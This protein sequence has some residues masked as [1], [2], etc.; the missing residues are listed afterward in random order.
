MAWLLSK[1]RDVLTGTPRMVPH[2]L[3]SRAALRQVLLGH[4]LGPGDRV[5]DATANGEFTPILEF[6]GMI[7]DGHNETL[8]THSSIRPRLVIARHEHRSSLELSRATALWLSRLCPGGTLVLIDPPRPDVLAAFPG[9]C[10]RFSTA[11]NTIA[12]LTIS[13]LLRAPPEWDALGLPTAGT[14]A[15]PA[16]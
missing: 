2:C 15:A 16:A 5:L 11:G 6:L 1:V 7:V 13:S 12:T 3:V 4:R 9:I 8:G 14:A 10:R